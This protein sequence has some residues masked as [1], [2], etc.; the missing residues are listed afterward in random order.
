MDME[1]SCQ[2][3]YSGA[4]HKRQENIHRQTGQYS[5]SKP[6]QHP[7]YNTLFTTP[8]EKIPKTKKLVPHSNSGQKNPRF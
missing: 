5:R 3:P 7:I 4:R 2:G 1:K 6:D 8:G